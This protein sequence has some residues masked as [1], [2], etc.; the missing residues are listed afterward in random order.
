MTSANANL[1]GKPEAVIGVGSGA[2]VRPTDSRMV[3]D[4]RAEPNN[5]PSCGYMPIQTSLLRNNGTMLMRFECPNCDQAAPKYKPSHA[6]A[7]DA[8]NAMKA[9][10][11]NEKS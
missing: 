9:I 11:P 10:R 5:C 8:W 2:V 1:P 3:R 7:C 6:E 4:F